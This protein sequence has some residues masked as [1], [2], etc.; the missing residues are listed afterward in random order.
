MGRAFARFVAAIV[1]I[2]GAFALVSTVI[3]LINSEIQ[4]ELLLL[5]LFLSTSLAG[6]IGGLA[7]LLSFDGPKYLRTQRMRIYGWGGMLIH[8]LLPT[9]LILIL[10]PMVIIVIPLLPWLRVQEEPA[11]SG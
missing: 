3:G 9:P 10:L 8:S 6:A 4:S 7:Y 11:T 5:A 1:M 2:L